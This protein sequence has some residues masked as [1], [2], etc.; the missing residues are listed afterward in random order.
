MA[1]MAKRFLYGQLNLLADLQLICFAQQIVPVF[2]HHALNPG[3]IL[4]IE[5]FKSS[6]G[7]QIIFNPTIPFVIQR[8]SGSVFDLIQGKDVGLHSQPRDFN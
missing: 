6:L 5:V 4:F 3:D 2:I 1:A 8:I 7:L